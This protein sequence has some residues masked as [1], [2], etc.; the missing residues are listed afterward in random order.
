MKLGK[1]IVLWRTRAACL[2]LASIAVFPAFSDDRTEELTS[3]VIDTLN[4]AYTVDGVEYTYT[5]KVDGSRWKTSTADQ[6]F[7]IIAPVQT[8]P[9][10]LTRQNAEQKSI[11]IQGSFD[12]HG[13]NWIDIYPTAAGGDG[14]PAEI[15]LR[16][17]TRFIDVWVWGSNLNYDL[18][19]YVRDNRGVIHAIPVGNL[20]Y[21]GWR[22]LRAHVPTSIPMVANIIPRSTHASTFVK[23]RVWT[24]PRERT[25]ID[26]QRDAKGQVTKIVPFYLY[27]SNVKVLTDV[28]ETVYDGDELSYPENTQKLWGSGNN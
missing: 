15:P 9:L 6:K 23:F 26:V 18:E 5:W 14:S 13:Y 21:I 10:A 22:N 20:H 16:G 24:D 4:G 1:K 8:G 27:L 12:R 11:G 2:I 17:R 7:P 19:A 3:I 28:Y 25:Y